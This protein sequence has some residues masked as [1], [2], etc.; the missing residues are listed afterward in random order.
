MR[1]LEY[2]LEV[3]NLSKRYNLGVRNF[4]DVVQ[5]LLRKKKASYHWALKDATFK[6]PSGKIVGVIGPNGAGKSTLLKILS[7]ITIPTAKI[8]P[9][10][11]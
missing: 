6:I 10:N 11:A 8:V 9:G 3:N 7:K 2:S 5:L 4:S 1:N